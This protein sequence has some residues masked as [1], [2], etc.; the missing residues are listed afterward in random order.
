MMQRL[1]ISNWKILLA[2]CLLLGGFA[3]AGC[4][5]SSTP[6]SLTSAPEQAAA[7]QA[8]TEQ[9]AAGATMAETP[10]QARAQVQ[11]QATPDA[12]DGAAGTGATVGEPL[13]ATPAL[14]LAAPSELLDS[15]RISASFIIT[16]LLPSG[17]RR[18]EST[19]LQG[20]WQ[21]TDGPAG[22]DAAFTL[23]NVSGNRRQELGMV[24]VGDAA[25]I[26]SDGAWST[27]ARDATLSYGDPDQL[28]SL[29]FITRVNRGEDLG[30][31]TL[32]GAEVT[33]YRLTDP[34]NF[35]AAVEDIFP[36]AEGTVQNVL[37]EG[38]V[39]D[40]GYVVKY[41]LHVNLA[42]AEILDDS[43][44]RLQV[45]QEASASYTLSDLDAIERIEWPADAQPPNTVSVPGFVPN[46]FPLPDGAKVTPRLGMVEIRTGEA[47]SDVAAFY[48]ARLSEL[49]WSFDGELGF[50]SAVKDGQ[51]ISLTILADE[52]SGETVVR[53]F[54][55]GE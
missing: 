27:V 36:M 20:T 52:V 23:I 18:I 12:P 50:Y 17:E 21:R 44:N 1:S 34:A 22:F 28:L 39:A 41:L 45:Q 30:K 16:S 53:V 51:R 29:P 55:V 14:A 10:D 33:H 11:P 4:G 3:L 37:L 19:Q 9:A 43:G 2:T 7:G 25:A 32:A 5:G 47:D 8:A 31:E 54:G 40:A 24:A 38:W 48:R 6:D 42:D 46:T 13:E 49:G 26:Q 15:Y 35:V